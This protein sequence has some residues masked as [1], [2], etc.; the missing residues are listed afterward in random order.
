MRKKNNFENATAF[1]SFA[2]FFVLL[3][4]GVASAANTTTCALLKGAACTMSGAIPDCCESGLACVIDSGT[5]SGTCCVPPNST[6]SCSAD[7]DCC[8]GVC[9]GGKCA[10]S[11]A[12]NAAC[13]LSADCADACPICAEYEGSSQCKSCIT[14]GSATACGISSDCCDGAFCSPTDS[15]C[16]TCLGN[17]TSCASDSVCC[18]SRCEFD[19][20]GERS[21]FPPV[22]ACSMEGGGCNSVGDCCGSPPSNNALYCDTSNPRPGTPSRAGT[23]RN[24]VPPGASCNV[25]GVNCTTGYSCTNTS[26][27]YRC[28]NPSVGTVLPAGWLVVGDAF[29]NVSNNP[30]TGS[31]ALRMNA[32]GYPSAYIYDNSLVLNN[33]SSY[34]LEMWINATAGPLRYSIY[35]PNN[36]AY[37]DEAG[38]WSVSPRSSL[39]YESPVI[40]AASTANGSYAKFSRAFY[41]LSRNVS[42]VQL[43]LYPPLDGSTAQ[44]DDVSI[45]EIHDFTIVGWV[46][47]GFP[48]QNN[49][50]L[51]YQMGTE[52]GSAQGI[53]WTLDSANRLAMRLSSADGGSIAPTADLSDFGLHM[54]ALSINR[55]G[56]Y[57][58]YLDGRLLSSSAF[59]LGRLN[60]TGAFYI[61]IAGADGAAFKGTVDEIRIYRRALT[62]SE[63]AAQYAGHFQSACLVSINAT[64]NDVP[65]LTS[66][67][68]TAQYNAYLRLRNLL[69][70]TIL[71]MPFDSNVSSSSR[72]AITD[73]SR[74]LSTGTL[75]G[76][77]WIPDGKI[78]GA[79]N[80]SAADDRIVLPSPLIMGTGDFTL[81]AWVRPTSFVTEADGNMIMGNYDSGNTGGIRFFVVGGTLMAQLGA[82]AASAA[83]PVPLGN[84]TH[85]AVSRRS[86]SIFFYVDGVPSGSASA[87]D[88][89]AGLKNFA[90]GNNPASVINRY[91]GAIDEVRVFSKALT[92]QEIGELYNDSSRVFSGQ[93]ASVSGAPC[94]GGPQDFCGVP[95]VPSRC[96]YLGQLC[97][98][99]SGSYYCAGED[100]Y[101]N[102][103]ASPA[104]CQSCGGTGEP[105]CSS[106]HLQ[107]DYNNV[108]VGSTCQCGGANQPCCLSNGKYDCSSPE[109]G[110]NVSA[111]PPL[112]QSCGGSDQVCCAGNNCSSGFSCSSGVCKCGGQLQACCLTG[113][114]CSAGL[115]CSNGFCSAPCGTQHAACCQPLNNCSSGLF[116]YGGTCECGSDGRVCCS[117]STCDNNVSLFCNSSNLCRS[118]GGAG[119]ACCPWGTNCTADL[120]CNNSVSPTPLCELCGQTGGQLC[121]YNG[122]NYSCTA[123]SLTCN[124]SASPKTCIA[125]GLDEQPCCVTGTGYNCTTDTACNTSISPLPVCQL[126]GQGDGQLCCYNGTN[127]SCTFP[128]L[129]CNNSA[130]PKVCKTCGG[131]NQP[132]CAT[133]IGYNCTEA[134]YGCNTSIS[135]MPLCKP[136]GEEGQPCCYNSSNVTAFDVCSASMG[137]ACNTSASPHVC[138]FPC[139]SAD[140]PCCH[141]SPNCTS[142]NLY[143]NTSASPSP[144]CQSCGGANQMCCPT[145][146][147]CSAGYACDM[148][149]LP[150]PTC[151][152]CGGG[153][154][155]CCYNGSDYNCTVLGFTCNSSASPKICVSCGGLNQPCCANGTGYNCSSG[156]ACNTSIAPLPLCMSCGGMTGQ[157]CC[158][159]NSCNSSL[160]LTCNITASPAVC[161]YRQC[162]GLGDTDCKCG[163]PDGAP[164][165]YSS[166]NTY[167]DC[168]GVGCADGFNMCQPACNFGGVAPVVPNP[169]YCITD[170]TVHNWEICPAP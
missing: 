93:V 149:T 84:W 59:S 143:C 131:A 140:Q 118:C 133:A 38:E 53:N 36:D 103:S 117:G 55:V 142:A 21:C 91:Y 29:F 46:R 127:Y 138:Y 51:L 96:G 97:C 74:S 73:Y 11:Y 87:A 108:C 137:F 31:G 10:V 163:I 168:T 92:A 63:I 62:A 42:H 169:C 124:T 64:Y 95:Y 132:C 71:S 105:C 18:S 86:G 106:P 107:C 44:V 82:T 26:N 49:S 104:I 136:C 167:C 54:F 102:S 120:A 111:G 145:G 50:A 116:C 22:Q 65:N 109:L 115:N 129:T 67:N 90:I 43:R 151:Q 112:C 99:A 39:G 154:Q 40:L 139:G 128:G 100:V 123:P 147:N 16:V 126:C 3:A 14:A 52:N 57:S 69:P 32:T 152:P 68:M 24:R 41:T 20:A 121:C 122:S 94:P 9:V 155:Q 28:V 146:S 76:A 45:T 34:Y 78:G 156:Y 37:L 8:L 23:C 6:A 170:G 114:A 165:C 75:S 81:S 134:G 161:A 113:D 88:S 12:C 148:S 1:L 4:C 130:S 98:Y 141:S 79:Y 25:S 47:A 101:C 135:P 33:S 48:Q 85:V 60:N 119:Q 153:G 7:S 144:I 160:A 27:G 66:K 17:G 72:G 35:D 80:F 157:L 58:A 77:A 15:K 164:K 159:G 125:C 19:S 56:N 13:T 150:L 30:R 166:D 61:G 89:I 2:L 83:L 5:A 158:V 162:T 110:C 70:E